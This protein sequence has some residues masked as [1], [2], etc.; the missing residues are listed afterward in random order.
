MDLANVG[1]QILND[2]EARAIRSVMT[3]KREALRCI[4]REMVMLSAAFTSYGSVGLGGFQLNCQYGLT[5]SQTATNWPV[6][7]RVF[8]FRFNSND[9]VFA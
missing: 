6:P 2:A 8:C 5:S 3:Q 1:R 4:E 7:C 9:S